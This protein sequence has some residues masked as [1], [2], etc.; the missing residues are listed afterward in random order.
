MG[1][2]TE[3]TE[4]VVEAIST[5]Q[6]ISQTWTSVKDYPLYKMFLSTGVNITA[7]QYVMKYLEKYGYIEMN[8]KSSLMSYRW[9]KLNETTIIDAK[10]IAEQAMKFYSAESK[11]DRE[12]RKNRKPKTIIPTQ[13]KIEKIKQKLEKPA[14]EGVRI[15]KL[16][17]FQLDDVCFVL[18]KKTI[19]EGRV[20]G[21]RKT[22]GSVLY[23]VSMGE[24]YDSLSEVYGDELFHSSESLLESLRKTIVKYE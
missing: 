20:E 2:R 18:N 6:G 7:A 13:N 4:K 17:R 16:R 1:T 10:R 12:E 14:D 11:K 8:G 22:G 3:T 19:C 5:L 9:K 21:M 15:S 23:E 24:N